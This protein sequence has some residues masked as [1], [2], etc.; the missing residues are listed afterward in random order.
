MEYKVNCMVAWPANAWC[1]SVNRPFP[2]LC[3]KHLGGR[4]SPSPPLE[5][6][7]TRRRVAYRGVMPE[8]PSSERPRRDHFAVALEE[9]PSTDNA[10]I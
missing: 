6:A 9:K 3:L 1:D 4:T 10:S 2:H 5:K 7:N 8:Y